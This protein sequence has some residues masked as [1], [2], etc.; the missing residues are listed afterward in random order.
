ME[1]S[2]TGQGMERVKPKIISGRKI[3]SVIRERLI[4]FAKKHRWLAA[5][6]NAY[7]I[8]LIILVESS[9]GF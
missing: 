8:L 9:P 5:N 6:N 7:I 4:D 2:I 3:V 1:K